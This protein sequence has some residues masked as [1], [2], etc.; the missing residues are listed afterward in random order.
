MPNYIIARGEISKQ[1]GLLNAMVFSAG[2]EKRDKAVALFSAQSRAEEFMQSAD[3][4]DP[5]QVV[6]LK[7][8][9]LG[10]WLFEAIRSSVRFL[11]VNPRPQK[12]RRGRPQAVVDL[13]SSLEVVGQKLAGWLKDGGEEMDQSEGS[14]SLFYCEGCGRIHVEADPDAQPD[15]CSQ[16]MVMLTLKSRD[17]QQESA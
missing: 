11:A 9:E 4:A 13:T 10:R 15:C 14:E 3:V 16:R 12:Q 2:R 5:V 7:P 6:E 8:G 17:K 1:S